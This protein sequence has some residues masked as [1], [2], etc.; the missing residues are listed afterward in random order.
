MNK[1]LIVSILVIFISVIYANDDELKILKSIKN[2]IVYDKRIY[3]VILNND[4]NRTKYKD[5]SGNTFNS[6]SEII[7]KLKNNI[8]ISQF[9]LRYG[10]TFKRKMLIGDFIFENKGTKNT[11]HIINQILIDDVTHIEKIMPNMIL[12]MQSM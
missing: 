9:E 3:K 2:G 11:L 1:I 4:D 12:N 7:V 8:D 6:K 5:T 10:L